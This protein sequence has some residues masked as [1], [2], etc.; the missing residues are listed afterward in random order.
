MRLIADATD[1]EDACLRA[2]GGLVPAEGLLDDVAI[3]A[4][5][6]T[7]VPVELRLELPADPRVLAEVRRTLRRWLIERG[8]TP[9]D[10]TEVTIAVS[11]AC[12]NAI[13]HAYSPSPAAFELTARADAQT[14]TIAVRDTGRWRAPRGQDRGRGLRIIETAMDDVQINAAESGTEVVMR[15]RLEAA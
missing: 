14:V 13:E 1:A 11:E 12:A 3:V 5:Q 2:V 15:R 9:A 7:P 10:L 8:A 6:K 4:I